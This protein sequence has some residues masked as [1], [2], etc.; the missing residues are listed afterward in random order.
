V[1]LSKRKLC[2]HGPGFVL[3]LSGYQVERKYPAMPEAVYVI[4]RIE[5]S[6]GCYL[7]KD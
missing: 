6:R 4:E 7:G 2:S 5:V 1:P 3:F